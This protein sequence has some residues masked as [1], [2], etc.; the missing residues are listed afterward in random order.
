MAR[1]WESRKEDL[2]VSFTSDT[3]LHPSPHLSAAHPSGSLKQQNS[4]VLESAGAVLPSSGPR[5]RCAHLSPQPCRQHGPRPA[6]VIPFSFPTASLWQPQ[7]L[8]Q[9]SIPTD[10]VPPSPHSG[11]HR[12]TTSAIMVWPL[13]N[14]LPSP[15]NGLEL[16]KARRGRGEP[17]LVNRLD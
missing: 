4:S 9:P 10:W 13:M 15:Q 11:C 5:W 16:E 8:T 1:Q 14:Q 3:R 12:G 7:A 2:N 17:S 6:S